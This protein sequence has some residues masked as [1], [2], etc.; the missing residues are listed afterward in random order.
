MS[1]SDRVRLGH[2]EPGPVTRLALEMAP[3]S[4]SSA[5]DFAQASATLRPF[6][7]QGATLDVWE[8]L[9]TL[10][11]GDLG[12]ARAVE[13]HLDA[14]TILDQA[15]STAVRGGTWGVFAAEAPGL[16]VA[17][18]PGAHGWTLTGTKP[19]C[20]LAGTLTDALVT[21][22]VDD[23]ERRLFRVRLDAAGV[24]VADGPWHARGLT[25]I[26]SADVTFDGARCHP[27]G[28]AG[29]Y[30][31]RAGFAWGG[32]SV[33]ACWFGGAVGLARDLL[34]ASREPDRAGDDLLLMHLGSLDA[35]IAAA[36]TSFA[37]AAAEL[38]RGRA[39]G[40]PGSLL[41]KRVRVTAA[42]LAEDV[43]V[44]VGHALGPRPLAKD[45]RHAKRVADLQLYVRQNHAA[46]DDVS[47]GRTARDSDA[48]W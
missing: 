14:L 19:W 7:G 23:T 4:V 3:D 37:D 18:S 11:A 12:V 13:P 30:L 5:L 45:P 9:A 20:S 15:G 44:Q 39:D 36:R 34:D 31:E 46:R 6:V 33:A 43:L 10:A 24:S 26:P 1:G 38:D 47:L 48:G 41:A 8:A 25:E 32:I 40:V 35:R 2:G 29:W 17:A 42:R 27:V 16:R 28:E 22:W 21:A